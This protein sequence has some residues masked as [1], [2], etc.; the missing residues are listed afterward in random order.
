MVCLLR[1]DVTEIGNG[2]P[3]PVCT[4]ARK[5]FRKRRRTSPGGSEEEGGAYIR[6]C[7]LDR[8]DRGGGGR[9]GGRG[10]HEKSKTNATFRRC[11]GN[12]VVSARLRN[13]RRV[14]RVR[15]RDSFLETP[16]LP[17]VVRIYLRDFR[18]ENNT[19][20]HVAQCKTHDRSKAV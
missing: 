15:R 4:V 6:F 14:G 11:Q 18:V 20:A 16:P 8:I 17:F 7:R 2:I 1:N 10:N 12:E 9:R 13:A 19:A 3:S 5:W